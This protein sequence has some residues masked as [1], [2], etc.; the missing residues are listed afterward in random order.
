MLYQA[1]PAEA[2]PLRLLALGDSLTAGYGLPAEQGFA[3]R[4]EEALKNRGFDV[5]VMN[6]GVS[7]DTTAG[8]LARLDWALSQG[9]DAVM[10]EL[11]ANDMLRGL[12]AKDAERN[13]DQMIR[14]LKER[15]L[16]VLL[17]G[18]KAQ[19][20]LGSDYAR[21]FDPIYAKLAKKHGIALY[22]F[23]L[24]GVVL[25]ADLNQPDGL[26]PNA[27]GVEVIVARLLP[28]VQKLLGQAG[29]RAP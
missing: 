25:S 20:N 22:P 28:H 14:R 15:G 21:E 12:P 2:A 5:K 8:G 9:A 17:L 18:M 3:P 1:L 26:H 13:L 10:V 16:P 23:F 27:K 4:L 6:A 11:G 24:E 29:R 7:G 19:A